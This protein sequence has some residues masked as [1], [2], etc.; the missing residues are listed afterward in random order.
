M[1]WNTSKHEQSVQLISLS[2]MLGNG[3]F[4]KHF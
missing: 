4:F 3:T 2:I 1:T